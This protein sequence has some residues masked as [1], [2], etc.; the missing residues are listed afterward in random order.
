MVQ[1]GHKTVGILSMQRVANYGSFLQAWA[2]RGILTELGAGVSFIDIEAG[3]PMPGQR[4]GI[5]A[6]YFA[7]LCELTGAAVTGRLGAKLRDR[8]YH[9]AMRARFRDEYYAMLGL[10]APAPERYDLAVI[11]SDMVFDCMQAAPWGFTPQLYGDIPE[12]DSVISYAAS[13]GS[14]TLEGILRAGVVDEIAENL[15]Q[16]TAVSVR[17]DNSHDIVRQLTGRDALKHLD[18][19]LVYDFATEMRGCDTRE[20]DY[21]VVYAYPGR[22]R[23]KAEIEAITGYARRSG[24]RLVSILAAY[25]WCD[26]AVTPTTP[27]DVLAWFRDADC[28]VTDTFHGTI[29]SVINHKRFCTLVRSSNTEKLTSLLGWLSLEGQRAATPNDIEGVLSAT[30][31]YAPTDA[32]IENEKIR[33]REYLATA[34]KSI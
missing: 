25:D 32:I 18:P 4:S 26:E 3:H 31:D 28:V 34:L 20:S 2:L 30:P 12:A 6:A 29:F 13:F 22:I 21:I 7:R 14:S 10:D 15:C 9:R 24:K 11:G 23:N 16:L 1:D 5:V 19:V 33:T 8:K 17:D 27:F